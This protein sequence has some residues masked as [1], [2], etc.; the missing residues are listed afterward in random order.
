MFSL[1]IKNKGENVK[2]I[3]FRYHELIYKLDQK[4][5]EKE[6][7]GEFGKFAIAIEISHIQDLI[8]LH[9]NILGI[10]HAN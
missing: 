1:N 4:I 6:K 5:Q 8:I 3:E 7:A 2:L 9:E 10:N